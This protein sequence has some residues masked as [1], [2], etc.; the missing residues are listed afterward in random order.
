MKGGHAPSLLILV[1]RHLLLQA[2][3][4]VPETFCPFSAAFTSSS[5]PTRAA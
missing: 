1:P 3:H 4:T 5:C 2:K